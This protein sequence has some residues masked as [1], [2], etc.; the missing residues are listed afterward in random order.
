MEGIDLDEV[1]AEQLAIR[2]EFNVETARRAHVERNQRVHRMA[3]VGERNRHVALPR[4]IVSPAHVIQPLR[5]D[6]D[7]LH[8]AQLGGIEV[9]EAM[10]AA[11]AA[12][13]LRRGPAVLAHLGGRATER[14]EA[15]NGGGEFFQ[16]ARQLRHDHDHMAHAKALGHEAARWFAWQRRTCD[17]GC[18]IYLT[19]LLGAAILDSKEIS[20]V[21]TVRTPL[22]QRGSGLRFRRGPRLGQ[23]SLCP[24][25]GVVDRSGPLK[26]KSTRIGVYK[27]YACRKPFTVKVGTILESSH[28]KL[29]IWLQA[30]FLLCSSKKG[31]SSHQLHRTLGVTLKTAWFMTRRIREAMCE[32]KLPGGIGGE[33][34][35]VEADEIYVGGKTKNRAYAEKLSRHEPVVALVE[36]KGRVAS[37]H[38]PNLNPTN[39]KPILK[40]HISPKSDLRTDESGVYTEIGKSFA[41]HEA[42]SHSA[43]KYSRGDAHTN[44]AEGY[45]S[46]PKRGIYGVYQS[47]QRAAFEEVFMRVRFPLQRACRTRGG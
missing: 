13:E 11:V 15:Q 23:R 40:E 22:P 47:R 32:G 7:M 38:V 14:L 16:L 28:A 12:K 39:L 37:F 31:I 41:S 8:T 5:L 9:S 43:K 18:A 1:V 26:G 46:V 35:F 3:I 24:H 2:T 42:V 6:A 27:C 19:Y 36:R 30:M 33:G 21:R 44:T 10:R 17:D 20:D 45:F 25:C 34:K 29:H 4:E